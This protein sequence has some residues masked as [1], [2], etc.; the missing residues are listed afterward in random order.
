MVTS[1][2][3][4]SWETLEYV[5]THH[6]VARIVGVFLPSNSASKDKLMW[7]CSS[8]GIFSASATFKLIAVYKCLDGSADWSLVCQ[9]DAPHSPLQL[10]S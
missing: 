4:W 10:L 7:R 3:E 9:N 8:D 5:L 1:G 6:I 2:G